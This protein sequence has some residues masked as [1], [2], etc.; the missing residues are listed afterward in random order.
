M[1]MTDLRALADQVTDEP[2]FVQ[3]VLALS[4]DWEDEREKEKASPSSPYGPG[5]NGWEN[6]NH[7]R[8]S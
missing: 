4:A 8:L 6:G 1:T 3:F 2:S 7:R 5:A